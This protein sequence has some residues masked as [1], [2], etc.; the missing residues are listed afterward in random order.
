MKRRSKLTHLMSLILAGTTCFSVIQA[1]D[2]VNFTIATSEETSEAANDKKAAKTHVTGRLILADEAK[3]ELGTW[4]GVHAVP[5]SPLVAA[6]LGLAAGMGLAVEHVVPK[7]PADKAGIRKHDVLK[8]FDDQ[9]LVNSEQF[10]VLVRSKEVN[11]S[12]QL[13]VVRE[14]REKKLTATLGEMKPEAISFDM[15]EFPLGKT[16]DRVTF[17][18][19]GGIGNVLV[20]RDVEDAKQ[21]F[22]TRIINLMNQNVTMSDDTGRYVLKTEDGKK[23]F[24]ATGK[25]GEVLFDGVIAADFDKSKLGPEVRLKLESLEKTSSTESDR[26]KDKPKGAS[27]GKGNVEFRIISKEEN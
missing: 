18:A 5:V 16:L 3:L 17:D 13:T 10:R 4:L 1:S 14:G 11:D 15:K 7:S 23:Y 24:V 12:V 21:G 20:L 6:Q 8:R 22:H 2:A 26:F 25:N 9:S 19:A 27:R